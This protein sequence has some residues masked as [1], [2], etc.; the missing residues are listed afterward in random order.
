MEPKK[1]FFRVSH[2]T[3]ES[4]WFIK[5]N[6]SAKVLYFYLCK[7]RNRFTD[8]RKGR[9][10]FARSD[11]QLSKDTGL[12]IPSI[13]RSRNELIKAGF[14]RYDKLNKRSGRYCAF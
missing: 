5:L 8:E 11:R 7:F 13:Y 6:P 2:Q 12:S 4:G 9:L 1:N 3:T 10:E 14:I